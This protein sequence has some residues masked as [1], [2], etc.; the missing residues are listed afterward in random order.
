MT[1]TRLGYGRPFTRTDLART[2]EDG[3]RYEVIDG[4][5]IVTP[6]AGR[7]HQRVVA[8]LSC[9]L[10]EACPTDLEVL[11][12]P[13]PV[14]LGEYTEVRPD[15]LVGPRDRFTDDDL[16]GPPRL[17]VEVLAPCTRTLD[18]H[19]KRERF[20]RS[21]TPA[22]WV[23]DPDEARL[24]AWELGP[25]GRCRQVTDVT[26]AQEYTAT[27]PYPVSVIPAELVR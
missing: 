12:G 23:V 14:G 21:G 25:D 22:Y 11:P 24:I 20:A 2:P 5:L 18:L 6:V 10:G 1:L 26:G 27:L 3:R 9:R 13:F 19:V 8:R 17:A 4:V 16:P 15:V 7:L